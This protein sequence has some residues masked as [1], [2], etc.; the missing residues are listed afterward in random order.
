MILL[1]II[2]KTGTLTIYFEAVTMKKYRWQILLSASLVLLSAVFY[3]IHFLIFR[4]SHHIFIYLV[5]DIAF[6]P[7]EVLFV[8]II[9]HKLLTMREKKAKLNKL[10]M[11]IG[12]FYSETGIDLLRMFS[13]GDN[14]AGFL[15]ASLNITTSWT[16]EKFIEAGAAL[17]DHSYSSTLSDQQLVEL[18]DYIIS[19]RNFTLSLLQN[20]T[21]LEHDAFTDC[22]WAVFHLCQELDL[23]DNLSSLPDAD[24]RHIDI[25][26]ERA[27][28]QT[29]SQWLSYMQHL[30]ADYPH[31][32]S[33]AMRTNPFN[34]NATPVIEE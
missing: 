33:L 23:R 21:L 27:Y 1:T 32:F 8:T 6:V 9:I 17:K 4:D 5:G 18:R 31:L 24:R 25:D 30:K 2:S 19:K 10:N 13:G 26:I 34:P 22:L 20:P 3:T 16:K 14:H 12:A 29:A 15:H 11:V 28:K 7:L